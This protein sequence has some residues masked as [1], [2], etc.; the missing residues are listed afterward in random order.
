MIIGYLRVSSQARYCS[1]RA[2]FP[3][4][5]AFDAA[6]DHTDARKATVRASGPKTVELPFM[7]VLANSRQ[8]PFGRSL[9]KIGPTVTG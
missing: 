6:V 9:D 3:Q 4:K 2:A 1:G 7:M 8:R 5:P